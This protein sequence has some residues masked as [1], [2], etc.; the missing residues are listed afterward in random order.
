MPFPKKDIEPLPAREA[1]A[2]WEQRRGRG[3]AQE[4]Q[5]FTLKGFSTLQ[6]AD[7]LGVVLQ[8][9]VSTRVPRDLPLRGSSPID[10]LG[11]N[12]L[13]TEGVD[14]RFSTFLLPSPLADVLL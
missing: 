2:Q 8:C 1:P 14:Q 9:P 11:L 3:P 6:S 5:I 4:P 10:W 13:F 12:R 7:Y